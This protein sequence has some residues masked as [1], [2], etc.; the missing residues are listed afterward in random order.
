MISPILPSIDADTVALDFGVFIAE[1]ARTYRC[2]R[3][4]II[5]AVLETI[6]LTPPSQPEAPSKPH[7]PAAQTDGEALSSSQ[8]SS[9][10]VELIP[11]PRPAM[12]VQAQEDDTSGASLR[13][14]S[15]PGA[16]CA[17]DRAPR[18]GK[19]VR[20]KALAAPS[21]P[22]RKQAYERVKAAFEADPSATVK[23]IA[24]AA[25]C[26]PT[27]ANTWVQQLRRERAARTTEALRAAPAKPQEAIE[28]TPAPEV[29]PAPEQPPATTPALPLPPPAIK[30]MHKAPTGRFYLVERGDVTSTRRYVHQSLAPCPTGPGPMMT[31]DRKW[32][33]I[34]QLIHFRNALKKW[35]GLTEMRKEAANA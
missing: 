22:K 31:T 2:S 5:A 17:E 28:P 23:A 3:E 35:P 1:R 15:L 27:T 34:G 26:H 9:P 12:T 32:A 18:T 19:P 7:A 25:G 11:E 21:K 14:N 10:S 16:E 33:W 30:V 6:P 24:E 20:A 13:S 4:A 29:A 8:P